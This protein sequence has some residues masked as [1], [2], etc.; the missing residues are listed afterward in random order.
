MNRP[1]R[2]ACNAI[3]HK[4]ALASASHLAQ[5]AVRPRAIGHPSQADNSTSLRTQRNA[6]ECTCRP[7]QTSS[8]SLAPHRAQISGPVPSAPTEN[9]EVKVTLRYIPAISAFLRDQG[10]AR[11]FAPLCDTFD[12]TAQPALFQLPVAKYI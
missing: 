12:D 4:A 5:G 10:T 9:R 6:L 3:L 11:P 7:R 8:T 2:T 1:S